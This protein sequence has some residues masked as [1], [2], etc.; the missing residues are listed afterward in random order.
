MSVNTVR[1]CVRVYVCMCV[2][3]YICVCVCV[4]VHV[5]VRVCL[6]VCVCVSINLHMF[7]CRR[8]SVCEH[9]DGKRCALHHMSQMVPMYL[10]IVYISAVP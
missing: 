4:C 9:V 1:A 6:H 3:I 10:A 8:M 2:C 7:V 5:C